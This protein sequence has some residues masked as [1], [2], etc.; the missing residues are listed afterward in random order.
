MISWLSYDSLY[1]IVYEFMMVMMVEMHSIAC[2]LY[3][4]PD[5][6]V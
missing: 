4:R 1:G 3:D 6:I 5:G 2:Y